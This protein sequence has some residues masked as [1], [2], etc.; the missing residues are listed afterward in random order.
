MYVIAHRGASAHKEENTLSSFEM[1]LSEGADMIE[2]D[3]RMSSDGRIILSHDDVYRNRQINESNLVDLKMLGPIAQISDVLRLLNGELPLNLEIKEPE[4]VEP[5]AHTLKKCMQYGWKPEH[6]LVSSFNHHALAHFK[7]LVPNVRIGAL[8]EGIPLDYSNF[9]SAL[10]A[11]SVH[12]SH[13][14]VNREFVEHAHDNGLKVLVY[15]VND[16]SVLDKMRGL[17]VDG[18]FTDY[19]GEAVAYLD[20]L[21]VEA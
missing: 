8:L 16:F 18:I 10:G 21:K 11:Y 1:A 7:R 3:L 5:L 15:T 19:P 4:V 14:F 6:F 13:Q 2:T 9:A 20:N 17:G 12:L